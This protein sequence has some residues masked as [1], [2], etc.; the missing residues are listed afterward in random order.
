MQLDGKLT[1]SCC[2]LY[3]KS[4]VVLSLCIK[5]GDSGVSVFFKI[6][7]L[8]KLDVKTLILPEAFKVH[9]TCIS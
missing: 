6:F 7:N 8:L 5:K 3:L 1:D 4:F 9:F 2:R